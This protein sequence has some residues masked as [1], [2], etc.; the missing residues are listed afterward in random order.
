MLWM[1]LPNKY[2]TE[3]LHCIRLG[4]LNTTK[5]RSEPP[6]TIFLSGLVVM[7]LGYFGS[8]ATHA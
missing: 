6:L 1:T 2:S 4:V 8:I 5:V 3:I 7:A